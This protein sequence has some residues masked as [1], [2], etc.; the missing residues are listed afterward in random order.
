[1][2]AFRIALLRYGNSAREV[3][4]GLS[5]FMVDG[6]WHSRGRYLD[7]AAE[8]RS[9]AVLERLVHYKRFDQ[10]E[11]HVICAL[12]IPDELVTDL[13]SRPA[14]WDGADLLPAAQ[15]LG[16][17]WCDR[18]TSPALRVPSAIS[19]GEQTRAVRLRLAVA[20]DGGTGTPPTLNRK[21]SVAASEAG[22][23]EAEMGCWSLVM[24]PLRG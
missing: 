12:S 19:E 6:R 13:P 4:S 23:G 10:L 18:Q 24:K 1:V 5:G 9:L 20:R 22:T 3:F 17:E 16:N 8:N 2:R 15:A 11:P 7:Y 14:G 21:G